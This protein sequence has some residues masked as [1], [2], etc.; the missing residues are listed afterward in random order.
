MKRQI[1]LLPD[2]VIKTMIKNE[3]HKIVNGKSN[4]RRIANATYNAS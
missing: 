1:S 4:M 2:K 3:M